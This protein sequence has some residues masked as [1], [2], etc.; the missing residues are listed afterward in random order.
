MTF[1]H[2]FDVLQTVSTILIVFFNDILSP[3]LKN[4]GYHQQIAT[5][6]FSTL[7]Q[8]HLYVYHSLTLF[9]TFLH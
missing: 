3:F 7:F 8:F 9:Q 1:Y 5:F 4:C 2:P 6:L